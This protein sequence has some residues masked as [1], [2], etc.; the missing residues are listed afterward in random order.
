M[1]GN[2]RRKISTYEDRNKTGVSGE[3]FNHFWSSCLLKTINEGV[4]TR[5]FHR[6]H[7]AT[8]KAALPLQYSVV[9][10]SQSSLRWAK[11]EIGRA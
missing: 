1:T 5:A 11:G 10:S 2:K 7:V 8:L 4:M 9:V 3:N 6:N